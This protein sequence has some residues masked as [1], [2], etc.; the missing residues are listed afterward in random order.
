[1]DAALTVAGRYG[2]AGASI[3]N[4]A[5]LAGISKSSLFAQFGSKEEL[6]IRIIQEYDRRFLAHVIE[7]ALASETAP[8]VESIALI[9][10]G[11]LAWIG[12]R[13]SSHHGCLYTAAG[14]ELDDVPGKPRDY[15]VRSVQRFLRMLKK[16]TRRAI[17]AREFLPDV[18]EDRFVTEFW[19]ILLAYHYMV[20]LLRKPNAATISRTSFE[21][22]V[23][24]ARGTR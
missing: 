11:W 22:L 1:M 7:P 19:G 18:D 15:L 20:R 10:S 24:R 9:F 23:D 6:Q 16:L 17:Q 8:A 4:I 12:E 2:L 5:E 14:A 3:A 13:D 21:A